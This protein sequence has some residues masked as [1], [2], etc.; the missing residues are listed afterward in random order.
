MANFNEFYNKKNQELPTNIIREA[1]EEF[2]PLPTLKVYNLIIEG[3]GNIHIYSEDKGF[4]QIL[5]DIK[6]I[7]NRNSIKNISIIR[8]ELIE[9]GYKI[10]EIIT[11]RI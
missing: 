1:K 2:R 7:N 4:S 5:V 8:N 9:K 3:L 11:G 6:K 10:V